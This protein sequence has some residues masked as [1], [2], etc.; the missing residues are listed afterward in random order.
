ML[1]G[2][3]LSAPDDDGLITD[4]QAQIT[5]NFTEAEAQSLATSLKYGALPIA[6]ENDPPVETIGPSL[7][8]D[9]LS[10]GIT[11]GI[12]GLLAGDALLP[13]LLPRPRPRRRRLADRGGRR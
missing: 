12:I 2:Q 9:Q 13:A 5:G 11:A 10:A 4:G 6:F 7:A 1:D 3:V 8:G